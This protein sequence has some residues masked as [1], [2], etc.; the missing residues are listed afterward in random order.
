ML[1]NARPFDLLNHTN[2][3]HAMKEALRFPVVHQNKEQVARWTADQFA[4]AED[5]LTAVPA[6][7]AEFWS[8]FLRLCELWPWMW[9]G[10][11]PTEEGYAP[12]RP[13]EGFVAYHRRDKA[14]ASLFIVEQHGPEEAALYL[15]LCQSG[16]S[17]PEAPRRV[18]E[19]GGPTDTPRHQ[20]EGITLTDV[21]TTKPEV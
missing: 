13:E 6:D 2:I 21:A 8:R 16:F 4:T 19:G 7:D 3:I 12:Q 5:W 1:L 20:T 9:I 10:K 17:R 11:T 18:R 14:L 15:Y